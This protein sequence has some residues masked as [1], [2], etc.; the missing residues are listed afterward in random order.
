MC[1]PHTCTQ[2][3]SGCSVAQHASTSQGV[4][5]VKGT[6]MQMSFFP[7]TNLLKL[8]LFSLICPLF[9]MLKEQI[10]SVILPEVIITTVMSS[11]F[12]SPDFKMGIISRKMPFLVVFKIS[13]LSALASCLLSQ[14]TAN[15]M[16]VPV[17]HFKNQEH[18][19]PRTLKGRLYRHSNLISFQTSFAEHPTATKP[20]SKKRLV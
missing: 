19:T 1:R 2:D 18:K 9:P 13:Q 8:P 7:D 5:Q 4:S 12:S 14:I 15:N 17:I 10:Y 20:L 6:W 16:D 3:W 11:T